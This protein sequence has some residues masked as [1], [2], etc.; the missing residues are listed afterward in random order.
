[1]QIGAFRDKAN[2]DSLA[3]QAKAKGFDAIVIDRDSLYKVQIGAFS[4]KENAEALV[5]QAK[6]AGFDAFIY[7]E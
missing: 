6:N 4:S 5:Q 1:M 3:A 2:A 7:Q